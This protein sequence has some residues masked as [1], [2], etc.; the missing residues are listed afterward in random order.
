MANVTVTFTITEFCL[1]TGVSEE[2]LNEIVGLGVIEPCENET[3]SWLFD[4]HAAIVVQ[5]ALRL[6][7]ELA[8]D[9]PGIAMTLT[10]LEE[11]DRL[12]QENRLLIQ[13][14]SRFI[15]HP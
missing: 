6:R 7:Q 3:T 15:K 1:H 4:D 13:R 12:R 14:L 2:E 8:L 9:W 5:R 11:N 10:L